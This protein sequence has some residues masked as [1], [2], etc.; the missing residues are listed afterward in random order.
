M[1][2]DLLVPPTKLIGGSKPAPV[3]AK[4]EHAGSFAISEEE[5]RELAELMDDD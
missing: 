4:P 1:S 2:T 3:S 5:E